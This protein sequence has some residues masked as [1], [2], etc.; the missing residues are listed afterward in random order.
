MATI[1]SYGGTD[2]YIYKSSTSNWADARDATTGT[3]T[4]RTATRGSQAIKAS[5]GAIRGGG[6]AWQVFRSFLRFDTSGISD[7]DE[8]FGIRLGCYGYAT[9][10]ADVF[11]VKAG[12]LADFQAAYFDLID[13]W[14][15]GVDNEGNVTKYS[16]EFTSWSYS[17]Y[18]NITLN[19]AA[20]TAI[21]DDDAFNIC[22][23]ESVH[24][25]R[26]VEPTVG[27]AYPASVPS[28]MYYADYTG[29][30]RDPYIKYT[31]AAVASADNATFFGANF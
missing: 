4:G 28:G 8:G 21:E 17:G 15:A 12:N 6:T 14:S 3:G 26:N 5:K 9:N 24:D 2:G 19:A 10:S 7:T 23:I 20:R 18:N 25:L 29:T 31:P 22:L 30:S 11:V 16:D 13:G 27:G 1:Y